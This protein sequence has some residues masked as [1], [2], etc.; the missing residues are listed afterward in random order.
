MQKLCFN[1]DVEKGVPML[2]SLPLSLH[3]SQRL[4]EVLNEQGCEECW[5]HWST[6]VITQLPAINTV[7]L[8]GLAVLPHALQYAPHCLHVLPFLLVWAS[9]GELHLMVD[10][11]LCPVCTVSPS[12]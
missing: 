1:P 8:P 10:M 4:S 5:F 3:T 6:N 9:A 2:T 12:A 7:T 11:Y